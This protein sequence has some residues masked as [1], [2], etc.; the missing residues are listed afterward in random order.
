MSA[1][2]TEAEIQ[3]AIQLDLGREPDLTLWRNNVGQASAEVCTRA[4]LMRLVSLL[5]SGHVLRA[6]ELLRALIKEP[7]RFTRYGLCV[8]SSDLI[9]IVAPRGI[10]L[11]LEVKRTIK[12]Q[13][14]PEQVMFLELINRRGG[15]GR[16]VRSV[17]DARKAYWDARE[18]A[19]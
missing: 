18:L 11:A 12:D 2:P 19:A 16:V 3:N 5:E 9:G 15:V 17:D 7:Q 8:G 14:T 10:I 13:P 1:A 4:H 6:L